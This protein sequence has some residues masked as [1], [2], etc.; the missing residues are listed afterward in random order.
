MERK[1][2][3]ERLKSCICSTCLYIRYLHSYYLPPF[4]YFYL[5]SMDG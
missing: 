1:I 3:N 4:I 5:P 2:S